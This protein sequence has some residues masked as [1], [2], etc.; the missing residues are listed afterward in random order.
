MKDE[1]NF[2][3]GLPDDLK[4]L[5][6]IGEDIHFALSLI[7]TCLAI[8]RQYGQST[9]I[10]LTALTHSVAYDTLCRA[11]EKGVEV[12]DDDVAMIMKTISI[13]VESAYCSLWGDIPV[14]LRNAIEV[15]AAN[16]RKDRYLVSEVTQAMETTK[17]LMLIE[18]RLTQNTT[19]PF[20][21]EIG[22][23]IN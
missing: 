23:S 6:P 2:K 11:E 13:A 17:Q 4:H 16:F 5:S 20:P 21:P 7:V 18:A 12:K 1:Q 15:A 8:L 3:K 10:I 19:N 9:P 22:S 14:E